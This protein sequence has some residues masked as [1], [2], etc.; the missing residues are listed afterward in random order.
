MIARH[1]SFTPSNIQSGF[2]NI[3]LV[4]VNRKILISK[5]QALPLR[6]PIY[7]PTETNTSHAASNPN[8]VNPEP[9]NTFSVEEIN[10]L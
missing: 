3:R 10:S 9:L 2:R 5:I 4:P 7:N 6:S 8:P 1:A